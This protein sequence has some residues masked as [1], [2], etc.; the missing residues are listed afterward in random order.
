MPNIKRLN[1]SKTKSKPATTLLPSSGPITVPTPTTNSTPLLLVN[2]RL[3]RGPK[4]GVIVIDNFYTNINQ[5]REFAL[6][7]DF[8]VAGNYPG[9]RTRSFA[10]PDLQRI[11]G[12]YVRPFG[13]EITE[14]PLPDGDGDKV[15]YNGSFQYTTSRERSWI[16]IDGFNNWAAV[17]FMTPDAP[18]TGGTGFYEFGPDGARDKREQGLLQNQAETDRFSQDM[19]KWKPVD[20]VGNV[21]N[22]MVL[23]DSTR[24]H[25]SQDYFGDCLQNGR[26]FQVFFFTTEF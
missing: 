22:R 21:Y 13:G 26:L 11:I 3:S 7:Q 20:T 1:D 18:L 9:K 25:M 19:T 23:F 10:T 16:H 14:F 4:C 17:V 5:V 15:C 2:D 12:N 6:T 24:F 8:Y